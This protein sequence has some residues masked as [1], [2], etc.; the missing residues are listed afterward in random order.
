MAGHFWRQ[1]FRSAV[2]VANRG[3]SSSAAEPAI[4][5]DEACR[6]LAEV[7][8]RTFTGGSWQEHACFVLVP[9]G[10]DPRIIQFTDPVVTELLVRL[11]ALPGFDDQLL[12][13][14]IGSQRAELVVLW[15]AASPPPAPRAADEQGPAKGS[16]APPAAEQPP[17]DFPV[18]E[19]RRPP[20]SDSRVPPSG[21]TSG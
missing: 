15:R 19:Q 16:P 9:S 5:L 7:A 10:G 1:F 18:P 17:A 21:P 20:A 12:L 3:L 2:R 4:D 6:D 11:R 8:V 13:T 14:V